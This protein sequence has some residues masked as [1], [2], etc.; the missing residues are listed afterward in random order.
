MTTSVTVK[1]CCADS[2]EVTVSV[3]GQPDVV[4]QSGESTTVYAF[5]ARVISV[6]E[7]AKA[8]VE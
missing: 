2:I 7:S 3:T 6:Q 1:A 4:L 5:D 8:V